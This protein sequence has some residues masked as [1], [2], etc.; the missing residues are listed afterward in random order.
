MKRPNQKTTHTNSANLN[1]FLPKKKTLLAGLLI[2]AMA[3][4]KAFCADNPDPVL[5]LL[6]QKGIIT[7][8]EA[9]KVKAEL[10]EKRTNEM[11][12][13]PA[14]KWMLGSGIKNIELFGDIRL[15]FEDRTVTDPGGGRIE[16]NRM[17]YALR[18]GARG[19]AFDDFYYGFRFDTAPNPRSPWVTFGTSASGTPYQGPFG[20]SQGGLFL[21]QIFLGWKPNEYV[22]ITAGKM[23]QPLYTTPMVWDTDFN[24]EGLAEHFKYKVGGATFFANLGQFLYEDT[25]PNKASRGY[26]GVGNLYPS[27]LGG[28]AG[29]AFLL[30]WQGGFQYDFTKDISFEIAPVLYTYTGHGAN[31][32]QSSSMVQPGFSGTFSG[33]GATN[34]PAGVPSAGWSG[35]PSGYEDGFNANQTGINNLLVLEIPWEIDFK[36]AELNARVFGDF[37][38]NLQGK[39]RA[40]AAQAAANSPPGPLQIGGV[41][42]IASA[43]THD[44]K[45][46]QVGFAI[47]NKNN[48]GLVYGAPTHRHAWEFRT[49]WQHVEQYA[50]DD[51]LIDSDFFEGRGN[52]EGV[53]AAVGYGLT[54]NVMTTFRYGHAHRINKMLGTGGSNQDI[55]QMNPIEHYDILQL[56]LTMRF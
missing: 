39:Q 21:G 28:T 8:A 44:T 38:D 17:R 37:A 14:S 34:G 11:A 49:Y 22:N 30:A 4:G 26:F 5:D 29:P 23:A 41:A 9:A 53:Y 19:D 13:M 46:Y 54:D 40:L 43:Q 1:R 25:N 52:L 42:P 2:S 47:G 7:D 56:D 15:R 45:A 36:I 55:P 27:T 16:L 31:T 50:L 10:N 6:L 35:F 3:M 33:Q 51:N 32:S 20:K 18:F 24:P 12:Q 48:L